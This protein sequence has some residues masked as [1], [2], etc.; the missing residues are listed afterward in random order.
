V[1]TTIQGKILCAKVQELGKPHAEIGFKRLELKVWC[2]LATDVVVLVVMHSVYQYLIIALPTVHTIAEWSAALQSRGPYALPESTWLIT[3]SQAWLLQHTEQLFCNLPA[4]T[5]DVAV[6][7]LLFFQ[8]PLKK[9]KIMGV[10][11]TGIKK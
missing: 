2:Q 8:F 4:W 10:M 3:S 1:Q 7:F 11:W 5:A 9:I 6:P